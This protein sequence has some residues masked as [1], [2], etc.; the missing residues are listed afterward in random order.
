MIRPGLVSISFRKLTTIEIIALC[1]RAGLQGIEWGGD[2]HVP[3]GDADVARDVAQAT[4]AAGLSVAAYG[5][6]YRVGE[7]QDNPEFADALA[8]AQALGAP[9]IRVWPG[10]RGSADADAAYRSQVVGD[11][12][13]IASM[14]AEAGIAVA[15]EFH[16]GTLTDTNDSALAMY[17]EANHPNLLAYWQPMVGHPLSYCVDGLTAL[18]PRLSNLHLFHWAVQDG[19]RVREPLATGTDRCAQYLAVADQA[20]GDRWALLEFV[21][22]DDPEQ[23]VADAAT[24]CALLAE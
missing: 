2:V 19:K 13:R 20:Q 4:V 14:A 9:T 15:C 17:Q 16:G 12:Q 8:S 21:R 11:L 7:T 10:K 1:V 18:L 24:L 22:D 5:S 6:Y 3:H 23:L